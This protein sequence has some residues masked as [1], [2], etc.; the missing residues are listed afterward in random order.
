MIS[1]LY[2]WSNKFY[3]FY[4][5]TVVGIISGNGV[6]INMYH[7]NYPSKSKLVLYKLLL[8]CNHHFKTAVVK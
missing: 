3:G 8:H 1:T 4:M 5:A 6:N 7:E 2:D